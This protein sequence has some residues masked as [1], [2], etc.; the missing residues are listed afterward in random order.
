MREHDSAPLARTIPDACK[1]L[2]LSRTTIYQLIA[3]GQIRSFKVGSRTLIPD[4]DLR[5]FVENK[6][7]VAA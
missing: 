7:G 5:K 1:L 6:L 4:E 3:D 2:S